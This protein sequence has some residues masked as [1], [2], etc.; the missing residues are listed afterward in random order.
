MP[1]P[2]R[3]LG[4]SRVP[5]T[6]R[7]R[8]GDADGHIGAGPHLVDARPGRTA[9]AAPPCATAM[10]SYDFGACTAEN[11]KGGGGGSGGWVS[12]AEREW[13]RLDLRAAESIATAGTHAFQ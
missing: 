13:Q 7:R 8:A 11:G 3:S 4:S 9:E 2:S 5:F 12:L 6:L 10:G 1:T